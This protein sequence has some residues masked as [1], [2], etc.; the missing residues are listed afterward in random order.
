[1]DIV[2]SL[3]RW[4]A[5]GRPVRSPSPGAGGPEVEYRPQND[6]RISKRG[7]VPDQGDFPLPPSRKAAM[8]EKLQQSWR[9]FKAAPPGKRFQEL[10]KRR[11]RA[12]LGLLTRLL[13]LGGGLLIMAV[14]LVLVPAP[15]PGW[16]IVF[17]GAGLIAQES[18]I[19]ARALD[20]A[21]LHLRRLM[22]WLLGTWR[23]A[24]ARAKVLIVLAGLALLGVA[25]FGAYFLIHEFTSYFKRPPPL[26]SPH[27]ELFFRLAVARL[28]KS[29]P[30]QERSAPGAMGSVLGTRARE[31]RPVSHGFR[32]RNHVAPEL[33]GKSI[34]QNHPTPASRCRPGR[35]GRQKG[36]RASEG[37]G[38]RHR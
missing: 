17:V 1:V 28:P 3:S 33:F 7:N 15:G 34:H 26:A 24:P 38:C 12:R 9:Q 8:F 4:K 14:G 23:R 36:P 37:A 6:N 22:K 2:G 19:A 10:Y 25:A 11:Q 31:T 32:I 5:R 27:Q 29:H 30:V 13:S 18:L 20:W 21:E 16:A 35:P